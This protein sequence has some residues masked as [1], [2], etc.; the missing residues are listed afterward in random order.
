MSFINDALKRAQA[1]KGGRTLG[2]EGVLQTG[3]EEGVLPRS[4]RGLTTALAVVVAVAA[5]AGA[6]SI[7]GD[8]GPGCNP[9]GT[10]PLPVLPPRLPGRGFLHPT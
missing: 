7:S 8:G 6:P 10:T 4:R 2:F 1:E 9:P 3:S 5:V